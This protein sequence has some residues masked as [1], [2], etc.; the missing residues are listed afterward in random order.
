MASRFR[1]D[2]LLAAGE[3][4]EAATGPVRPIDPQGNL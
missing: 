4:I 1:E 3:V 2:L